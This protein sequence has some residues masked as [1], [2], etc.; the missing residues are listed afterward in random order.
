[1]RANAVGRCDNEEDPILFGLATIDG[2]RVYISKRVKRV[3]RVFCSGDT[4]K[5]SELLLRVLAEP[6]TPSQRVHRIRQELIERF[7]NHLGFVVVS[8]LVREIHADKHSGF[9]T[10]AHRWCSWGMRC[11]ARTPHSH[12]LNVPAAA[13]YGC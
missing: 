1:M 8:L 4:K 6:K 3:A 7:P 5:G 9:S 10:G 13:L 12:V 11:H 2:G